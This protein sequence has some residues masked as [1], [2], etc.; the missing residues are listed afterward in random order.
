LGQNFNRKIG[1]GI[2]PKSLRV[3]VLSEYYEHWVYN[4]IVHEGLEKISFGYKYK[5][6]ISEYVIPES[7]KTIEVR[8]HGK[9]IS[10][11]LLKKLDILI[12]AWMGLSCITLTNNKKNTA[13]VIWL[14]NKN[15]K[16]DNKAISDK[17]GIHTIRHVPQAW[18]LNEKMYLEVVKEKENYKVENKKIKRGL[19]ILTKRKREEEKDEK[20]EKEEK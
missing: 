6:I 7:V 5:Y 10:E 13:R 18:Y 15:N 4:A 16:I 1:T 9:V 17:I 12:Y 14:G 2:I 3:L 11:R 20:E 8:G 19:L